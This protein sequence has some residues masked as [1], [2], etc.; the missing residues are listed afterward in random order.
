MTSAK[1]RSLAG[2]VSAGLVV[3]LA[4][5]SSPSTGAAPSSSAA[6]PAA[7]PAAA[8]AAASAPAAAPVTIQFWGWNQGQQA[9]ADLWN[10]THP[11]IQVKYVKQAGNPET[12]T[13]LTNAAKAGGEAACLAQSPW[14]L[15]SQVVDG[16]IQPVDQLAGYKDKFTANAL[17][18]VKVGDHLYGIPFGGNPTFILYN[19]TAYDAAGV[20]LPKTWQELIDAGKKLKAKGINVI[21]FAGEDPSTLQNLAWQAGA[22]W[23]SIS[24]DAWKVD[25]NGPES[26][27]A[28]A[29]LQQLTDNDLVSHETYAQWDALMQKFDSGTMVSI[30]TSTWQLG[31]YAQN[32]KKS[33][34]NWVVA[35]LPTLDGTLATPGG[36]NSYIVPK[37]CTH[38]DEAV[39]FGAWLATDPESLKIL[40]DPKKGSASYP[41][42]PDPTPYMPVLM[43][44]SLLGKNTDGVDDI[45]KRA[46]QATVQGWVSGPNETA[47][48][49]ELATQWGK[50][51]KK[52]ITFA[53]ALDNVQAF[54]V[55]DLKKRGIKVA[56]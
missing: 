12:A 50:A 40:T 26:K 21:N 52:E 7:S 42:I 17:D 8:S 51:V 35:D 22:K 10:S 46:D 6:A 1:R 18:G 11:D 53:K 23:Y 4:A 45:V 20:A 49:A 44:R 16:T 3:A 39:K 5:C 48:G 33:L 37:G 29:I 38:V 14:Q 24:G 15:A 43:D 36:F 19:K 30:P 47:M 28:A 34:G 9:Q 31:A 13:A 56:E 27:K 55:A 41:V 25:I 54:A 32:F 2:G